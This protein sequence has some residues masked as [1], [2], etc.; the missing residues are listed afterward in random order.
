M[1]S[2]K[3]T[4]SLGTKM[5]IYVILT[6]LFAAFGV[7][8]LSF[9]INSSQIDSYFKRLTVN[10]AKYA[11]AFVDVDF[12]KQLRAVAESDEYQ[13]I[14]NKAEEEDDDTAVVEYLKAKG[15]WDKYVEERDE[16]IGYVEDMTDVKYLYVVAWG[17]GS[18]HDMYLLDADDVAFY[19]TGYYE[20][21]EAEFEGV[22]P[23]GIIDPVISKGDWGWLCSG[24]VPIYDE[25]GNLVCH[26]GCD[27]D[28]EDVMSAR[29]TNLSYVL[30]GALAVTA[31]I[32]AGAIFFVRRQVV[33]P[34]D[35]ISNGIKKFT[36][37]AG[38]DYYASNVID[39]DIH[40]RDEIG[41]IY[42]EVHSMQ[43]RIV[44]Y[45]NDITNI[46]LDKE[47]AE[48]EIGE[49]S[50]EAYKD[51]LTGVGNKSAY[52]RKVS[53]MDSEL[54]K[55]VNEF[56]VV[57]MDVNLLK[58]INDNYGHSAGDAYLKGCCRMICDAFKHSPVY[59]IGGDEFVA[60]L[61][62]EDFKFRRNRLSDLHLASDESFKDM[63]VDP[64]LRYSVS[65][66]MAVYSHGEDEGVESVFKRADK[67]MYEDK[68]S[69][70]DQNGIVSDDRG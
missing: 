66:G 15:L 12:M 42:H 11:S 9:Y 20:E 58:S 36:P 8:M 32:L 35:K 45:I 60:I 64:W 13:A 22:D 57:M 62:G 44:D 5:Y 28:M 48:E 21:R 34:L 18:D 59:R 1:G 23:Y 37:G 26:M 53:E 51:P 69:F 46:T 29:W 41:V 63:S 56:A 16:L 10:S 55:S 25:E 54:G 4:P 3:R 24:Y 68:M 47:K 17:V 33:V 7:C 14:R 19:E 6:V 39:E 43:T 67:Q 70:K 50:R 38:K 52:N 49:I 40:S 2:K 65:A 27:V 30:E 31:I 61:T